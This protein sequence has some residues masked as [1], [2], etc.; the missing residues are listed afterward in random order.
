MIG[1]F[2]VLKLKLYQSNVVDPRI[3]LAYEEF[4]L[5]NI[6][7]NE[8]I[9]F[10]WQS[11]NAVVIGRNQNPYQECNISLMEKDGVVMVRRLS[12][13]GAV[14]HDLGNLNFAF[15]A[16]NE[17][18]DL[19]RNYDIIL[20]ALSQLGITAERSGRNDLVYGNRKFSGNAFITEE[21]ASL[22]H[23]TLLIDANVKKVMNYLTVNHKKLETKGF[24]SVT[25]RIINLNEINEI[26]S[27][28]SIIETVKNIISKDYIVEFYDK[29]PNT[30]VTSEYITKYYSHEWNFGDFPA[31]DFKVDKKF[32]WGLITIGMLVKDGYVQEMKISTD[33]LLADSFQI[34][35]DKLLHGELTFPNITRAVVES[36]EDIEMIDDLKTLFKEA[37]FT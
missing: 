10:F 8:I 17:C 3:N 19:T 25:S 35:R 14:Y 21:H 1:V 16:R 4:F 11:E 9:L 28:D 32:K 12:G 2:I 26:I 31:F 5:S 20:R 36:F 24:D 7:E 18:Y 23:G 15:I 13:G 33:S 22:H 6:D 37:L 34:L 30:D 29:L 27:I